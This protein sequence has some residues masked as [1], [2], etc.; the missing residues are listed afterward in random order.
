[1][2]E[3]RAPLWRFRELDTLRRTFLQRAGR[4]IR[5]GGKPILSMNTNAAARLTDERMA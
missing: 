4:I 1:M 3:K 2:T 5:P